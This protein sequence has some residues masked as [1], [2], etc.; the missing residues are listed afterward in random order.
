MR[1]DDLELPAASTGVCVSNMMADTS[2]GWE[3]LPAKP[4]TM[5]RFRGRL[6]HRNWQLL[7]RGATA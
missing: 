7:L 2:S 3:T 6:R 1:R 5:D 4:A